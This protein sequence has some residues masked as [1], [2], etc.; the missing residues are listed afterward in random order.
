MT[1]TWVLETNVFSEASFD[2]MVAHFKANDIP[3]HTVRIIPFSHEV[4]GPIPQIDGPVVVYGSIGIQKLADRMGWTCF[5]DDEQFSSTAYKALGELFLNHD[6]IVMPLSDV[7]LRFDELPDPFFIKPDG[8]YKQFAGQVISKA[9]FEGWLKNMI[10]IGYLEDN[11]FD[12]ACAPVKELGREWRVVVVDGKISSASL[13]KE[14]NW[15]GMKAHLVDVLPIGVS[16]AVEMAH[17]LH[18]PAPVYVIDICEEFGSWVRYGEEIG[19]TD[20]RVIEY[21]TFN[22]AG[23]YA[24]DVAK[25][26][27][28]INAYMMK[29]F[30][31]ACQA[32]HFLDTL[33]RKMT[34]KRIREVFEDPRNAIL[35]LE[36]REED[37][38][39]FRVARD[40]YLDHMFQKPG[41]RY[42]RKFDAW[43]DELIRMYRNAILTKFPTATPVKEDA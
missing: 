1:V 33:A 5:H 13:Y 41:D 38:K 29:P 6:T 17:A 28:D 2:A 25:I 26:I 34:P 23:L 22:S 20:Y 35:G 24:C 14:P 10:E 4:D 43:R 15:P 21:N 16:M 39:Y 36:L 12:V 42:G 7:F 31:C 30:D 19:K 11:N 3:Y 32:L 8:D 37:Y 27:D 40:A 18:I 9:D